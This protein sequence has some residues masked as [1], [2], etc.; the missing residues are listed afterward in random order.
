[1]MTTDK[2]LL[3]AYNKELEMTFP[4]TLKDLIDSHRF[5]RSLNQQ[6]QP[7]WLKALEDG[8]QRGFAEGKTQALEQDYLSIDSLRSMTLEEVSNRIQDFTGGRDD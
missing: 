2:E 5:L 4:M 7:Q 1:M 8:R 6:F 3:E